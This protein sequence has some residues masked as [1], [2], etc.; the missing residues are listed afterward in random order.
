MICGVRLAG[1]KGVNISCRRDPDYWIPTTTTKTTTITTATTTTTMS[2]SDGNETSSSAM[3]QDVAANV[4]ELSNSE[5]NGNDAGGL[6]FGRR[7]T[8][9][10]TFFAGKNV[11]SLQRVADHP[12]FDWLIRCVILNNLQAIKSS[13]V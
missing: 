6:S 7:F 11:Y 8:Y 12:L 2:E 3:P 4:G 9:R 10:G 5:N 13:F 1:G